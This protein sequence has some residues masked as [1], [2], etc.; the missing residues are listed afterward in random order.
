MKILKM[1]SDGRNLRELDGLEMQ[2]QCFSL[3]VTLLGPEKSVT[4]SKCHNNRRF[5]SI[6][7]SFWISYGL[8]KL[9]Q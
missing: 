6:K 9:S 8:Q 1:L 2:I 4:I 5:Y 3:I 7:L